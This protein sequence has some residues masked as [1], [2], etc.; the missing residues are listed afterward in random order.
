ME[1]LS[2]NATAQGLA[3]S[4]EIGPEVPGHVQ[5]GP[6]RIRQVLLN[7][8]GNAIKFI[9]FGEVVVRAAL[10]QGGAEQ[11][12]PEVQISVRDTGV[13]IA[14]E[15]LEAIFDPFSQADVSTT[16][17]FAGTG[18][19]LSISSQFLSLMGGPLSVESKVGEGSSFTI[20]L[21]AHGASEGVAG[22]DD[23]ATH[24]ERS[25]FPLERP[26]QPA[27]LSST[28]PFSALDRA[29][30]GQLAVLL[31]E[32]DPINREVAK[33]I[34]K[35]LGVEPDLVTNGREAVASCRDKDDDVVLMDLHMPE[36]D[37]AE[38]SRLIRSEQRAGREPC[39]IALTASATEADQERCRNAGMDGWLSK[40]VIVADLRAA[41]HA[42]L[43]G[44]QQGARAARGELTTSLPG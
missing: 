17:R 25:S 44:R 4:T 33:R 35:K 1:I 39:L 27:E 37:G 28:Q 41:L 31:A 19:G 20:H 26:E 11:Q 16:R 12:A 7:L 30:L 40:P 18:L 22:V 2:T 14:P 42:A 43:T 32:A 8:M 13:G 34:L 36:M 38:A 23:T 9:A 5:T 10:V 29:R 21:P 3:L 6:T 24:I 15:R